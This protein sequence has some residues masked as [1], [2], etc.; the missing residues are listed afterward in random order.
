M[1]AS[2]IAPPELGEIVL[3]HP[4]QAAMRLAEHDSMW[5]S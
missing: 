1:T 5:S 3:N 4:L 2:N